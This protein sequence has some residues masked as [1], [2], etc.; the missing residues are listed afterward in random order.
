M[1]SWPFFA[2]EGG[3]PQEMQIGKRAFEIFGREGRPQARAVQDSLQ[4][5]REIRKIRPSPRQKQGRIVA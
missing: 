4:A 2:Q 3:G 5:E 1:P